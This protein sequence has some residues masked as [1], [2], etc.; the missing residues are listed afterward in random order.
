M[1][2]WV[3]GNVWRAAF[4]SICVLLILL[5]ASFAV[6]SAFQIE[7]QVTYTCEV[8]TVP[9]LGIYSNAACT[10]SLSSMQFSGYPSDSFSIPIYAKN[11]G[12]VTMTVTATLIPATIS[13]GTISLTNGSPSSVGPGIMR[14]YTFGLNYAS[15]ASSGNYTGMSV[16]FIGTQ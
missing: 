10:L 2:R 6:H 11:E 3:T 15:M 13:F 4:L 14:S 12:T 16:N 5:I 1:K 9:N 7:K 8:K